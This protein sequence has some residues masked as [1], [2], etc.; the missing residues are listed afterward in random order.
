M[1][2]K[3]PKL[4]MAEMLLEQQRLQSE[5]IVNNTQKTSKANEIKKNHEEEAKRGILDN[6]EAEAK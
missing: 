3:D 2:M 5:K 6:T 1:S 4:A